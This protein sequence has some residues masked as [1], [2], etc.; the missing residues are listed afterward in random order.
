MEII[1]RR[2]R[3][4]DAELLKTVRLAALETDPYA[5]GTTFEEAS[6]LSAADWADRVA[7][8]ASGSGRTM[9]FACDGDEVIGLMG[10]YRDTPESSVV[11]VFSSWVAP[12]ARRRGIGRQ[13]LQAVVDWARDT[14]ASAV[15]L[16]VTRGNDPAHR[17][18]IEMGFVETGE[19][20]PL[21]SDPC[22]DEIRMV[23]PLS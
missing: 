13:L 9:F 21:P 17:L 6:R 18:Y 23:L 10:G 14:S 3:V 19:H 4:D 15:Q 8:S 7:W 2:V 1:L 16:W 12:A 20:Q 11:E 22:K 5:F